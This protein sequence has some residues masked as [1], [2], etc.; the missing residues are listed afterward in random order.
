M[1]TN[2]KELGGYQVLKK[3][4]KYGVTEGGPGIAMLIENPNWLFESI[5]GE[6]LSLG[7]HI[8]A[9]QLAQRVSHKFSG[10]SLAPGHIE[11]SV[12]E[13][14]CDSGRD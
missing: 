12:V 6:T 3:S 9:T 5:A 2:N 8:V 14:L 4:E 11:I 7:P 13:R 10:D 1:I